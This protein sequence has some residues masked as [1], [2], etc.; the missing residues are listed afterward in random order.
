M[1]AS[2]AKPSTPDRYQII[3]GTD[4]D[5]NARESGCA[6][7]AGTIVTRTAAAPDALS[8]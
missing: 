6:G 8:G 2:A 5:G 3:G 7:A 4:D 1:I